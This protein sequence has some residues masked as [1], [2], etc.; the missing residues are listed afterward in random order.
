MR[1][2]LEINSL[3]ISN[4]S[5]VGNYTK[6]L[7]EALD[8]EVAIKVDGFY[9]DFLKK[10]PIAN[11]RVKHTRIYHLN[12]PQ[13]IYAKMA[14]Y[15]IAPWFDVFLPKVDITI[16]PNFVLWPTLKS[17]L[18][19]VVIHDLAFLKFPEV[20][21]DKNLAHLQRVVPR[22]V[23]EA[24]LIITVSEAV[25]A[26]LLATYATLTPERVLVTPSLLDMD[27]LNADASV[28]VHAQYN[29]PTDKY[30]LFT[31][32][33]EPRKN[34]DV[35]VDAY[36]KLSPAM[37][38]QYSLVLA[39]NI[40]WKSNELIQKIK[41]LQGKGLNI[42]AP[43]RYRESDAASLYK[44]ASVFVLP[45]LYE[46]FGM[47][48]LEAMACSV[49]VI[50]SGIPVLREVASDAAAFVDPKNPDELAGTLDRLLNNA[51]AANK[52]IEAGHKNLLRFSW[53]TNVSILTEKI[54]ELLKK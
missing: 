36:T 38:S 54:T 1:Y 6:L 13:R 9:F 46:G 50:A 12:F 17:R 44:K 51:A 10:H 37:Q 8:N 23:R 27:Y 33:I 18:T 45:S 52:L 35:L 31:G 19:A 25:K 34:L 53:K 24:D 43:G 32:N 26:E 28:D 48:I 4:R 3:S 39:G 40:G 21:E 7:T 41:H 15:G 49:P 2:R 16:F 20:V 30:I 47:P 14:S 42:I 11:L 29:I 22:A 5:G